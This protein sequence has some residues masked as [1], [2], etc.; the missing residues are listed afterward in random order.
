M[1]LLVLLVLLGGCHKLFS[2][3]AVDEVPDDASDNGIDASIDAARV[4]CP[5]T[6]AVYDEDG[7]SIDDRC[8]ACP[9]IASDDLN[10]DD[11]E[12]PNACDL[13]LAPADKILFAATFAEAIDLTAFETSGT[14]WS[15]TGKGTITLSPGAMLRTKLPYAATAVEVRTAE[16]TS[17][18]V[19]GMFGVGTTT[20]A[21]N[22]HTSDCAGTNPSK[23]CVRLAGTTSQSELG[24]GPGQLRKT[25][26]L[27]TTTP[28]THCDIEDSSKT[29]V[30]ASGDV[31]LGDAQIQVTTNGDARAIVTSIV[32]YGAAN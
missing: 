18:A 10:A 4:T 26:L 22:V 13:N 9:T 32:I 27:R 11:D 29:L 25:M 28:A 23:T 31:A 3:E 16:V 17:T 30:R 24:S 1:R 5:V 6:P 7:D 20:A 14:T 19:T 15:A 2:L 21:C 8:D 12:L